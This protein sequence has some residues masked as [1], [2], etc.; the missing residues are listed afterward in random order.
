MG[1]LSLSRS[2]KVT[3][4]GLWGAGGVCGMSTSSPSSARA[5]R[6]SLPVA[7]ASKER[8]KR[9]HHHHFVFEHAKECNTP[10]NVPVFVH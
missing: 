8:V 9:D 5:R 2:G 4:K 1:R 7:C 6:G 3:G 10:F